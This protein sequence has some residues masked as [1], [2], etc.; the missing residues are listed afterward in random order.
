MDFSK[1]FDNVKHLL[2]GE[3]LK[4]LNLNPYII[5]W[6]LNFLMDRKQRLVFRGN[7]YKWYHVNKGT[8]QGSVSGP[9][10]FNLFIND[11]EIREN[12]DTSIVK[13]AD[14]TT[15]LVKLC[16]D[17]PDLSEN[18][19]KQYFEWSEDNYMPC[20]VSKCNELLICKKTT[21]QVTPINSIKQKGTLKILG[22]TFQSNNRFVEHIKIKLME[23]NRCLYILRCM[24]QEGYQQPDIDYL[25]LSLV[26]PKLTY[27][28]PIYAAS[29]PE[30]TTVQNF[31]TRCFKR[32]YISDHIQILD[33]L[34]SA[35]RGIF[36]KVSGTPNHPLFPILPTV[37][38]S[39][40]C[41]RN[42]RS[43]LPKINT[44]RFKTS[45]IN[46]LHFKYKLVV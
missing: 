23:A 8:T 38:A 22:V 36:K 13:Y 20:N 45:F 2:V 31:L 44:E 33:L 26:L 7:A 30:L 32:K 9:H 1:A 37:K 35:D 11:L 18:V 17:R 10:L 19:L 15:L 6:Y 4:A 41:L 40:L 5:N 42:H 14:D 12:E 43:Q 24:R 16:K 28:L 25:F 29:L 3:K 46:R 27:G 21:G 39:S 34:E